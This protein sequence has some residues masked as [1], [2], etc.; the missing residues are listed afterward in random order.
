VK[1]TAGQ[2]VNLVARHEKAGVVRAKVTLGG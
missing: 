2:S 1:A